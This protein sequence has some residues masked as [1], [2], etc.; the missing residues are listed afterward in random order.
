LEAE[1]VFCHTVDLIV[2]L[3]LEDFFWG[4]A[5][6]PTGGLATGLLQVRPPHSASA[7]RAFHFYPLPE[8][9]VLS[10]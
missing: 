3:L 1:F 9:T 4:M 7:L 8:R 5:N 2:Q 6:P 10:S